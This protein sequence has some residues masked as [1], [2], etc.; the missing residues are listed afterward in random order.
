MYRIALCLPSAV[1][2]RALQALCQEYFTRRAEP[3]QIHA[4]TEKKLDSLVKSD[5]LFLSAEGPRPNGLDTAQA[6]RQAGGRGAI[7]FLASGPEYAMEAF[8]VFASQYFIPPVSQ[9]Q[10]FAMLDQ[11]LMAQ[12]GTYFVVSTREGLIRV[13]HRDVEYVECT[14]HILH[15]HLTDGS[16]VRSTTLRVPLK[17][18]LADLMEKG[19]FYQ[20]HRSYVI[21]LD[22]AKQ[23][24][25][26][27]FV[28]ESG[29]RVP[30]PRGRLA[31]AREVFL[32]QFA[33]AENQTSV[34]PG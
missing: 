31:E 32:A 14:D 25:D 18:A 15:F 20:P 30:V 34:F 6:I 17:E 33:P 4:V 11:I 19:R 22:A 24:T 3:L 1:Q 13:A 28:M 27:E 21:N 26:T 23:L 9:Q 8:G 5:L 2:R 10:L 7:V 16:M 29:A 12:R